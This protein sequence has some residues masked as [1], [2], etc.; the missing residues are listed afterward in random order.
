MSGTALEQFLKLHTQGSPGSF[1]RHS[2]PDPARRDPDPI[3][4]GGAW[5]PASTQLPGDADAACL[6]TT[7]W[8]V[9]RCTHISSTLF[10]KERSQTRRCQHHLAA[11]RKCKCSVSTQTY[12]IRVCRLTRSLGDFRYLRVWDTL[13]YNRLPK[14]WLRAF[15]GWS[16]GVLTLPILDHWVSEHF[17]ASWAASSLSLSRSPSGSCGWLPAGKGR[18]S[19]L[20]LFPW[21]VLTM[22]FRRKASQWPGSKLGILTSVP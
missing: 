14:S 15:S 19:A 7:L 8:V 16:M 22:S 21:V 9:P 18:P 17:W 4:L 1:I 20:T 10:L 13:V 6:R 11:C 12:G 2:F 3:G 5:S